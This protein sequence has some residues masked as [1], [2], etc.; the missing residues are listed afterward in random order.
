MVALCCLVMFVL[1][2]GTQG[3]RV[4]CTFRS[5]GASS[6]LAGWQRTM[7]TCLLLVL[8]VDRG[9]MWVEMSG[10]FGWQRRMMTC[11]SVADLFDSDSEL[12]AGLEGLYGPLAKLL[13]VCDMTEAATMHRYFDHGLPVNSC[14]AVTNI[15]AATH[16]NSNSSNTAQAWH[17]HGPRSKRK[18][19]KKVRNR[20]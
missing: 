20:R 8:Q 11:L 9:D 18:K 6:G 1:A 10:L 2:V 16:A 15:L 19:A 7:L 13:L 12:G 4:G 5:K 17:H 14:D 3:C